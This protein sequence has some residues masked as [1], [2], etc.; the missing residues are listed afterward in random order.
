MSWNIFK[1]KVKPEYLP[2]P[3]SY[4]QLT[5]LSVPEVSDGL[6]KTFLLTEVPR[7]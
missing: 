1:I 2:S 5:A 3:L 6:T 4:E 7:W